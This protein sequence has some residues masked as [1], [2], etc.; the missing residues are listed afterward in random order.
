MDRPSSRFLAQIAFVVIALAVTGWGC[1]NPIE[2]IATIF[3]GP[4]ASTFKGVSAH[5]AAQKINLVPGSLIEM[6]QTFL[7]F[8]AKIAA[9]LAG[10]NKEG[11]RMIAVE[12]FAPTNVA[13]VSWKLSTKVE[14]DASVK[15]REEARKQGKPEP[16]PI[17]VDKVGEGIMR[18]FNLKDGH[19]LY[20]PAFW[21]ETPTGTSLGT[22]GI[23]L[24]DD[25][26]QS[27]SRNRVATLDFG[28]LDADINGAV[29]KVAEF[30]DAFAKLEGQADAAARTDVFRLDGDKD[31]VEWPLKV[32]GQ[33]VKVEAIKAHTWFGEI[34]VLNN[35]QD[36][37][38]LKA[39]L[40]PLAGGAA[41]AFT[42]LG[43]LK[44]LV[45][46]EVTELKDVQE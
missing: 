30:K 40:N 5:D 18:G 10:E 33:D 28:L 16:E 25:Q 13:D 3:S 36:P 26:Y 35:R 32:N 17:M 37:L 6:R 23:W 1:V 21:P 34:V 20:L 14:A 31:A 2:K 29:A 19:S 42:N 22:T 4:K 44:A 11:V 38:V 27:L 41:S 43:A 45:G 15:A 24:S 9:A 39:T 46:Y 7:G 12:R 8:G